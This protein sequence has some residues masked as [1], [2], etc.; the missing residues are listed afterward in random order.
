MSIKYITN[1]FHQLPEVVT[2]YK[3]LFNN[4]D[5]RVWS[6]SPLSLYFRRGYRYF[7]PLALNNI[8]VIVDIGANRGLFFFSALSYFKPKFALAVEPIPH[9]SN[10]I[11]EQIK[12]F[13]E[14]QSAVFQGV[15]SNAPGKINFNI[16]ANQS[17][18][19]INKPVLSAEKAYGKSLNIVDSI[20]VDTETLDRLSN[21]YNFTSIDLIKIDV[22]GAERL[23]IEGGY[24]SIRKCKYLIIEVLFENHY[25]SQS[26]FFELDKLLQKAGLRLGTIYN[27]E[28]D[29]RGY[30]LQ[31]D[32]LYVR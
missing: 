12:L 2:L 8:N 22:Q 10:S 27:L 17:S 5:P 31:C 32:A 21:K 16:I 7:M 23:V 4:N 25:E 9:L 19:S 29:D 18:S 28:R 14:T 6:L 3:D 24:D 11:Q 13:K 1:K 30:L 26:D 20:M 15:V